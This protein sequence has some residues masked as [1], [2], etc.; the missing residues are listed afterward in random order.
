MDHTV[1]HPELYSA[2]WL[3]DDYRGMPYRRLGPTGLRVS[4]I[5]IGLWKNGC[6]ET[7]DGA[8]IDEKTTLQ[9]FDRAAELGVLFW[10]TAN[11]Y[12]NGSGNSERI[13]GRW[14][15]KN[16]DQRR[17][18]VL[19]TKIYGGMDGFTPNHCRLS[20]SNIIESVKASLGRLQ[21]DTIDLLYFH[22]PDPSTPAEESLATIE[23]LVGR[24]LV[25]YFAVSN[26]SPDQL[27][28][29]RALE[30]NF[31][32]RSRVV[33]VQNQ[34]D[35]LQGESAAQR[36][37]LAYAA[38]H[39]LSHIAWSPLAR[40]LLTD[41]YLDPKKAGPGDRLYDEKSLD[42]AT[43]PEAVAKIG[44]LAKLAQAWGLELSQLALAYMLTIPGMGP[45]IPTTSSVKQLES[46]AAASKVQFT[47]EQLAAI[48]AV[49][50]W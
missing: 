10:D 31:S 5:G 38:R 9:I 41:K 45:V 16:P 33:A 43:S 4:N 3:T 26:F 32:V 20:R 39:G 1:P 22:A 24:D 6:P 18:V 35:L 47:A 15:K 30:P 44:S 23:D 48:K 50:G 8:R 40:G 27:A 34:F 46:N 36:G 17:N 25:R 14:L 49:V 29:F 11:R 2:P 37:A 12:N 28:H 13:I 21:V 7:G 19:A 42:K